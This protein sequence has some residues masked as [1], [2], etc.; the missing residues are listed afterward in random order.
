MSPKAAGRTVNELFN[1]GGR[2]GGDNVG[3]G[4]ARPGGR[5]G[6]LQP[7]QFLQDTL[8][9]SAASPNNPRQADR[10][11]QAGDQS[12]VFVADVRTGWVDG[13]TDSHVLGQPCASASPVF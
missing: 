7:M 6:D 11:A 1:R 4:G 8:Q 13:Q 3:S 10:P 2:G 9:C 12:V 5:R